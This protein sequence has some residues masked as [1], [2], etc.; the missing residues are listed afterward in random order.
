MSLDLDYKK[1]YELLSDF[2][3]QIF[4]NKSKIK[5]DEQKFK[6]NKNKKFFSSQ[7]YWRQKYERIILH[8]YKISRFVFDEYIIKNKDKIRINMVDTSNI[9]IPILLTYFD[10]KKLIPKIE[11]RPDFESY[12]ESKTL[13]DKGKHNIFKK[14]NCQKIIRNPKISQKIKIYALDSMLSGSKSLITSEYQYFKFSPFELLY[15]CQLN[16]GKYYDYLERFLKYQKKKYFKKFSSQT[17]NFRIKFMNDIK[18]FF[19]NKEYTKY[20]IFIYRYLK[21]IKNYLGGFQ[22]NKSTK[23]FILSELI[24]LRLSKETYHKIFSLNLIDM[25]NPPSDIKVHCD[26]ASIYANTCKILPNQIG[27]L[28]YRNYDTIFSR[29]K[30][31]PNNYKLTL[32]DNQQLPPYWFIKKYCSYLDM[33]VLYFRVKDSDYRL[34]LVN[35]FSDYYQNLKNISKNKEIGLDLIKDLTKISKRKRKIK[36]FYT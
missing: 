8:T 9:P 17:P 29:I 3:N 20:D 23:I 5:S 12:L 11:N 30:K 22:L 33:M 1:K 24:K 10:Q 28:S 19:Q 15:N 18:L 36:Q 34:S 26:I 16:F 35:D 6:Y 32:L 7:H 14:I 31:V 2:C 13:T 4:D 21:F 25:V 27:F